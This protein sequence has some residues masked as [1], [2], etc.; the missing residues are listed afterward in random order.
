MG[1]TEGSLGK[2]GGWADGVE[3]LYR[4]VEGLRDVDCLFLLLLWHYIPQR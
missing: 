2:V 3:W 1:G 4:E